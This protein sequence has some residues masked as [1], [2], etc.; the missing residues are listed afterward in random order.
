MLG[1]LGLY[2]GIG[3]TDVTGMP[4]Y[5][6]YPHLLITSLLV[7]DLG[8]TVYSVGITPARSC[9]GTR[10]AGHVQGSPF[11][12]VAGRSFARLPAWG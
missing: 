3:V 9:Y 1:T 10:L 8:W 4:A 7:H 5:A 2:V 11:P 12:R 6:T